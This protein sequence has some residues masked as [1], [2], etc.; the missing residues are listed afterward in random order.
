MGL[1]GLIGL[2]VSI[3][4][5]EFCH[6]IVARKYGMPMKGITLFIFG[7]VAEMSEEPVS[8]KAEFFMAIAGPIASILLGLIFFGIF[9]VSKIYE[10]AQPVKGVLNYLM[11]IN[12]ILAGFNLIPAFPLD[13]GRIL[14]SI[15]WAIKNDLQ[16]ATRISSKFGSGF[17]IILMV[18]GALS[19]LGG[20]FIG[21]LWWLLIGLFIKG[22][23]QG[24]YQ[25]LLFRNILSGKS[26]GELM[27]ADPVAIPADINLQNAVEDYF[28]KYHHRL[29]PIVSDGQLK[30]CVNVKKLHDF[31]RGFWQEKNIGEIADNCDENNTVDINDDAFDILRR[32][33]SE[34]KSRFIVTQNDR[35]MGIITQKDLLD[36]L[37][38]RSDLESQ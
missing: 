24:S 11:F 15:L 28:Y 16:K 7:G 31:P 12:F 38:I 30:G 25:N 4:F 36:Y 35:L 23:S 33:N 32:M 1:G 13:G 9:R 14:R 6:S 8:P 22:A 2:V 34:Q 5:H 29:Y 26:A 21:G 19:I 18:L 17:A 37:L 20:N 10:W 27:T 3:V